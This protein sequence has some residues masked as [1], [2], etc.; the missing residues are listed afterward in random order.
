LRMWI[1][2]GFDLGNHTFSH[3]DYHHVKRKAYFDDVMKGE[4]ITR[5]LMASYGKSLKYFRHPFLHTGESKERSD[6]LQA[7]LRGKGYREAP[8]TIDN[9]DWI[10]SLAYESAMV[11]GDSTLM[12]SVGADY[13]CYMEK[14]LKYYESQSMKLFG[15]NIRHVLLLHANA[16]NADYL[17][18]LAGMYESNNYKFVS[19][20]EALED[21]AYLTKI[22]TFNR[23]W[24]ISWLDRWALSMGKE[25][26]FFKDEPGTPEYIM[27]LAGTAN[28]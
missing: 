18:E 7:F 12:K 10:F 6:S 24:G 14:K 16:I 2:S 8:V 15:R 4:R 5:P 19:L 22:T 28:E 26:T 27:R 21:E 3:M 1:E 17:G 20:T 13:I 9:S 23:S 11:T 25:G